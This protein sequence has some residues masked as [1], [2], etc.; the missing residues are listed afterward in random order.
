MTLI[1]N[2][3]HQSLSTI[4]NR[5]AFID[6]VEKKARTK[7]YFSLMLVDVVRFSDV[8]TSFGMKVGDQILLE[9]A[10]RILTLFKGEVELG[11]ISGDVFG[12]IFEGKHSRSCLHKR[13]QHLIEHFKTPMYYE[14]HAFIADFNVGAVAMT[15]GHFELVQFV[16]KAEAALKYAKENKFDNFYVL[17]LAEKP[18]TGR[19]L[20]L[21]ADL[22]RAL[23]NK[24]LELYLQ[25][26]VELKSF[27]IVGV[28]C[29]LRWNHPLDGVLFP[30]PLI[31]AAESYNMVTELAYWTLEEA[32]RI[33]TKLQHDNIDIKL[34]VNMSPTQLYDNKLIPTLLNLQ[35]K[36][37][38]PLNLFELELTEDMVLSNSL[39]VKKQLSELDALG[40]AISIDDFGK[41]YSNL[42]YIRD[43]AI[44]ALKIDKSF[45]LELEKS[46]IN[47]AII[48]ATQVIA[49][50]KNCEVI[51][52]GVET[53]NQLAI[54]QKLQV[55]TAQGFLFSKA[56]KVSE[57]TELYKKRSGRI[58]ENEL[59]E[60]V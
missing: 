3:V 35:E 37:Q 20:A 8:T 54:L 47:E 7:P 27:T 25:P 56:I 48:K 26:K 31:E 19:S 45:V 36:Y 50:A 4:S 59:A 18:D 42:S 2:C 39:M 60:V 53:P 34:S 23:V 29:L 49:R 12:L 16:A 21:K 40:I 58:V 11:R 30:G 10:N 33:K 24:E 17:D 1:M 41:G 15:N 22:T 46:P 43:I 55:E 28:E 6:E 13:Y 57:F 38:L 51:A 9:I 5:L 14:D 52:E 32:F 44:H